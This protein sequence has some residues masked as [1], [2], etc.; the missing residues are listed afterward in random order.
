MTYELNTTI[1]LGDSEYDCTIEFSRSAYRP[2]QVS[3]PVE[4][5]SPAEGGELEDVVLTVYRG[6]NPH[7]VG[8]FDAPEDMDMDDVPAPERDLLT[9]AMHDHADECDWGDAADRGDAEYD[10]RR[11]ALLEERP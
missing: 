4:A 8:A 3:G 11:D 7:R 9:Q 1:E 5:C 10:R 6:W 2:A